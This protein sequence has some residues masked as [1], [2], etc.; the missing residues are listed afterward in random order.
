MIGFHS[1]SWRLEFGRRTASIQKA[2]A[3]DRGKRRSSSQGQRGLGKEK[4][5]ITG[6]I[7]REILIGH[8]F[9]SEE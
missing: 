7:R 2:E 8:M 9:L 4:S 3:A 1:T 5:R 6:G